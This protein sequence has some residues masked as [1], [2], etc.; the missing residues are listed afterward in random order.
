MQ[1]QDLLLNGNKHFRLDTWVSAAQSL[2]QTPAEKAL[3]VKN[4]KTQ[5]T[6]WGPDNPATDLHEY[7]NKEWGA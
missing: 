6:Y 4:A 7:A 5:I 3:L 1:Q 2:G